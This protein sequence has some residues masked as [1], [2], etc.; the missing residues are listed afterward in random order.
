MTGNLK[1]VLPFVLASLWQTG[2]VMA[3][4]PVVLGDPTVPIAQAWEHKTFGDPI[5]Y[6][7]VV[8]DGRAAIL[9]SGVG[10]ASGLFRGVRYSVSQHPWLEWSWRADLLR[11]DADIRI[12]KKHDFA[13]SIFLIFGRKT[14]L[15]RNPLT[16]GY[17]WTNERIAA[18]EMVI[19]PYHRGNTRMFVLQSGPDQLGQWVSE[20]RNV[21]EDF[22]A[23]FGEDPPD[24]VEVLEV[25][26]DS[27]QTNEPVRTFYGAISALAE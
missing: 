1:F 24:M 26:S 5:D 8:D 9:A 4:E 3:G 11:D 20:R 19:S 14:W 7:L 15:N 18:G 25:F 27:D 12:K 6:Q 17:V 21:V 23:A 16:L 2:A 10:A 22:R 13:G